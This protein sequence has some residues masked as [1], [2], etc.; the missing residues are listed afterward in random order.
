MAIVTSDSGVGRAVLGGV[1][2]A[3]RNFDWALETIDPSVT[4]ADFSQF[5]EL[6]A[7]ADGV[8]VRLRQIW[9]VVR[10]FLRPGT[11]VVGIDI[12]PFPGSG[13]WAVVNPANQRIGEMAADELTADGCACHAFVPALPPVPWG[14]ARGR[15]FLERARAAGG[16]ARRYE[17]RTTWKGVAE[18][19]A[20]ASWLSELP[21]PFG[22]FARNDVIAGFVLRACKRAGIDVPREAKIVGADD[23]ET[24]CLYASPSLSSVRID[25]EGGGR[26]A[27]EA[28]RR[29]FGK[30]CPARPVALVFD[31][32]GVTRRL[33]TGRPGP[34]GD[35][36]LAAGLAFISRHFGERLV[37]ATDVAAAMGLGRRQAE[38]LFR[39]AGK[40]IRGELEAVR[41]ARVKTLLASTGMTLESIAVECGFSTG[42]Y[43][44]GLFRRRFGVS[45]GS[46]RRDARAPGRP[47]EPDARRRAGKR[48][49]CARSLNFSVDSRREI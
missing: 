34:E 24:L 1:A 31:P 40:S 38:R 25:H 33:S 27:A 3:A 8:I 17:P 39:N 41:L 15:G 42:I 2:G 29:S 19:D 7:L 9:L 28:L 10:P 5:A 35:A 16:D 23:D 32:S 6:L 11:P 47:A 37:G 36:R 4:G 43:L 30:P 14:D 20:L 12:A 48:S 46:W 18:R 49:P 45:P 26:R 13:L 44:S 22:V 21:R